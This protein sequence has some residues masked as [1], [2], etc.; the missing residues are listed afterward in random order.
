[1]ILFA[2]VG[3]RTE[4]KENSAT[5]EY[6]AALAGMG[7]VELFLFRGSFVMEYR[8]SE[9]LTAKSGRESGL[10]RWKAAEPF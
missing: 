10:M 2:Y 6:G 5:S 8:T 9:P 1:V 3:Q 7:C 4:V